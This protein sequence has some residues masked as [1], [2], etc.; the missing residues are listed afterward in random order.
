MR[1]LLSS[2]P[3]TVI[4]RLGPNTSGRISDGSGFSPESEIPDPNLDLNA[5]A[6]FAN[7]C[8]RSWGSAVRVALRRSTGYHARKYLGEAWERN[9]C[10]QLNGGTTSEEDETAEKGAAWAA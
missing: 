9:L 1:Y 3:R 4:Q 5:A 10:R 7:S 6:E 2:K 8:G